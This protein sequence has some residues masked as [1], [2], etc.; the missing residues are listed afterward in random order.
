M[1]QNIS[2]QSAHSPSDHLLVE[3][4]NLTRKQVLKL[5]TMSR[6][7]MG[8]PGQAALNDPAQNPHFGKRVHSMTPPSEQLKE[9]SQVVLN[10]PTPRNSLKQSLIPSS[11]KKN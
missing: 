9:I 1:P 7:K 10:D 11:P 4:W 5:R 6:C 8:I 2:L 3:T